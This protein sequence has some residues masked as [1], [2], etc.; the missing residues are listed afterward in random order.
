MFC[1]S[2]VHC[3]SPGVQELLTSLYIFC[4][5]ILHC[6]I[7]FI[8]Y[9]YVLDSSVVIIFDDSTNAYCSRQR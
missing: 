6:Q 4:G 8:P 9:R 5:I 7:S 3:V 1:K 2:L